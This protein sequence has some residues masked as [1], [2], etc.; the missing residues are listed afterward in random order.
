[1]TDQFTGQTLDRY[2]IIRQVG[3]D[4][5]G[6]VFQA[7]DPALERAVAIR[8]IN[9]SISRQP[10]FRENFTQVARI[11]ARLDHPSLVQVFDFGEAR[12]IQY[13]V[14]EFIRGDNLEKLLRSLRSDGRWIPLN[15]AA[16]VVRQLGLALEYVR[17]QG[18]PQRSL[19]PAN[20][21]IKPMQSDRLPY[22]PVLVDLGLE[23]VF[24]GG[25]GENPL[26]APAYLS[27]EGALGRNTNARSDVYSLGVL[28]FELT[29]GQLPFPIQSMEDAVR[30][31]TRQPLPPPG[32]F[33]P[34]M[35][36]QLASVITQA[37]EK[38]PEG[39]FGSPA[40]LINE[41]GKILPVV[42]QVHSVP[43]VFE[44]AASLLVPYRQ[45]MTGAM[46]EAPA[47]RA[48]EEAPTEPEVPA[49]TQAIPGRAVEG[50]AQLSI[51]M[52]NPQLA[53]EPGS[54]LASSLTL[55]NRGAVPGTFRVILEGT[56]STWVSLTPPVVYLE[57][58]EQETVNLY[59]Q[60][61]RV[62]ES[63]AGRYP[64]T[65]RAADQQSPGRF[66]E[67]RGTLTVGVF[68]AFRSELVTQRLSSGE[69]GQITVTNRGNAQDTFHFSFRGPAGELAFTPP[70]SPL[71]LGEGQ[72]GVAEFRIGLRLPRWIGSERAHPYEVQVASASGEAQVLRGELISQPVLPVWAVGLVLFMLLCITGGT[73]LFL[74]GASLQGTRGT[75]TAIALQTGIARA[76]EA[77]FQAET[78][79]AL[80]LADANVATLQA[81]TAEALTA[82]AVFETALVETAT[83]QADLA[84][85]VAAQE[86]ALAA[87]AAADAAAATELAATATALA[88]V[89]QEAAAQTATAQV[90]IIQT[91]TAQA[92][93]LQTATAQAAIL[94]TATAQAATALAAA[95]T[96]TAQAAVTPP[97]PPEARRIVYLYT[98]A[99]NIAAAF[100]EMLDGRG[101]QVDP[102]P[103]DAIL[104]TDFTPY[105]AIVVG[106][107]TGTEEMWGDPEGAWSNALF[108]TGLPILG[109]GEGGFSLFGRAQLAIGWNN[110][111]VFEGPNVVV[112]D[113]AHPVWTTPQQISIPANRVLTLYQD[114]IPAV[115]VIVPAPVEDVLLIGGRRNVPAQFTI[116]Q[117]DER[118]L[119]W[120]Y[121]GGPADMTPVGQQA[122]V[123]ALYSLLPPLP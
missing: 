57:P 80:F 31:H 75:A 68:S 122:F 86:T 51:S 102:L 69:V 98:T 58:G 5:L 12:G 104:T 1:M 59:I 16:G 44:S 27:P 42:A 19:R 32:S 55:M 39:R 35:P 38:S 9:P 7:H 107:D 70:Q 18:A 22:L 119:L 61:P 88:A 85:T 110:G 82:T 77:T 62:P 46:V 99:T 28:L 64:I 89:D 2:T 67:A 3:E 78:A 6:P 13:I 74:S 112:V 53:V 37:L 10:N 50:Q 114:N 26:V 121:A 47:R 72:S 45:S 111:I 25:L 23:R 49:A 40:E 11:A 123:N 94:Q 21:M 81:V 63:R 117:Q 87:T 54:S 79:T 91:A 73:V 71:R 97:P 109:L 95:L 56:P 90:A 30:Y 33:H 76:A 100:T 108:Q 83:A 24:E 48:P 118:Y 52:E 4:E 17:S 84:A 14:M 43:P 93:I 66:F 41:L 105:E 106:P 29:T 65:V 103:L 120:G 36:E 115:A 8:I 113:P 96:A 15:E 20:I 34:D 92:G 60:P 101:F 116:V